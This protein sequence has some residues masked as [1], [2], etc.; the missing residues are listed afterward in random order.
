L[1]AQES[2]L[3]FKLVGSSVET[4]ILLRKELHFS[5]DKY[6]KSVDPEIW[7]KTLSKKAFSNY[8]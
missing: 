3:P 1:D 2:I 4:A 8:N 5:W 6:E 7:I